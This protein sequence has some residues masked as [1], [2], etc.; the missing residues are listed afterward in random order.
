MHFVY[1]LYSA[2]AD[3]YYVGQTANLDH[4]LQRHNRGEVTSTKAYVPWELKHSEAH[5]TR[6]EAMRREREIKARKSR[7]YIEELIGS[8]S[9]VGRVP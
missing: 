2:S 1:I 3:R 8:R 7:R 9:S 5:E 4:R 6:S